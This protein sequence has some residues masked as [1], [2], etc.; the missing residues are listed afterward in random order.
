MYGKHFNL[1]FCYFYFTVVRSCAF[2][3]VGAFVGCVVAGPVGGAVGGVVGKSMMFD[4]IAYPIK[5]LR[6][7]WCRALHA[8]VRKSDNYSEQ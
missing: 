5:S 6:F 3:G 2:A 8:E 4:K 1:V 7:D